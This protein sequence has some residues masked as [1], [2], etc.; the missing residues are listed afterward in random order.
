MN[1]NKTPIDEHLKRLWV[2]HKR[3][4]IVINELSDKGFSE[5]EIKRALNQLLKQN[6]RNLFTSHAIQLLFGIIF[7]ILAFIL[8]NHSQKTNNIL[9]GYLSVLSVLAGFILSTNGLRKI[10]RLGNIN[11]FG[12]V[13]NSEKDF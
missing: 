12:G 1:D 9:S 5:E 11:L 7:I 6:L 8:L 3:K 13:K 10:L 2:K 4:G